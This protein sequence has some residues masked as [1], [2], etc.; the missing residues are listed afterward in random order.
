MVPTPLVYRAIDAFEEQIAKY[1][2]HPAFSRFGAVN[3]TNSDLVNLSEAWAWEQ[4]TEAER[5]AMA[6]TLAGEHANKHRRRGINLTVAAAGH[7]KNGT[8]LLAVRRTMCGAPTDFSPVPELQIAGEA[9]RKVQVRQAFRLA[10]EALLHW[11]L[12]RLDGGPMTTAA[13]AEAF[14]EARARHPPLNNG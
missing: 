7:L 12:R 4:P 1:L 9:W 14:L 11:I 6:E 3:V 10:L 2:E 13:L 8:D 5:Q